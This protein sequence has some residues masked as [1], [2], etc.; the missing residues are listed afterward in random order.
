MRITLL[1]FWLPTPEDAIAR[2][3][4]R[5]I[6]CGHHIPMEVIRRRYYSSVWNMRNLYLPLADEAEI[7]DITDR[8]RVLIAD[9]RENLA[10]FV[11][12]PE[13]WKKIG[14]AVR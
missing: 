12:D 5:V 13:R 7:Y 10:L 4:R 9:K 8:Q 6:Q 3:A 11:P 14:E 2:I 1:Y